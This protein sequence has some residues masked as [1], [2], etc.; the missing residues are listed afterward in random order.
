[1][2]IIV[3]GC[4]R[5]GSGLA[6]VMLRRGHT[7]T[8]I[9]TQAAAFAV[10][11]NAFHG[12]T[13]LGNGLDHAVLMT[14]GIERADGLA[15]VTNSDEINIVVARLARTVFHV[16]RVVARVVEPHKAEIYERL[17]VRTIATTTWGIGQM[18][19]LL[20]RSD[21]NVIASLGNEI[22]LVEVEIRRALA[23]RAIF[24]MIIPGEVQIVA[25]TRGGKSFL[26]STNTILQIGD[27]VQIAIVSTSADRV[28]TMLE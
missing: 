25:V 14:A 26:P 8:A 9:D 12:H 18:A 7:V 5:M 19:N 1:M 28:K 24:N 23:G 17:G 13:L 15:A 2:N 3:I 10:L 4:G 11:G 27:I 21:L 20:N 6:E 16:P 22:E